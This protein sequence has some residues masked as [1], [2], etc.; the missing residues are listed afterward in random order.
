MKVLPGKGWVARNPLLC[1]YV[2]AIGLLASIAGHHMTLVIAIVIQSVMTMLVRLE[3]T[4]ATLFKTNAE[5]LAKIDDLS[6][7]DGR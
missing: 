1:V 5:L 2:T 4:R 7:G 3:V 6:S